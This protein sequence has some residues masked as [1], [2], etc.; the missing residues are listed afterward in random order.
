M[1]GAPE[2]NAPPQNLPSIISGTKVPFHSAPRRH[3]P[4]FFIALSPPR[5]R[6]LARTNRRV[7]AIEFVTIA[8]SVV[9][10]LRALP[11][12]LELIQPRPRLKIIVVATSQHVR[13]IK[14]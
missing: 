13:K 4:C 8:T 9:P 7:G 1:L 2:A 5:P 12:L 6:D 3:K 11:R 14:T 10:G